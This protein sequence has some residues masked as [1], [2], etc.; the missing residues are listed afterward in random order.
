MVL[1]RR[2]WLA[3]L[4]LS[5]PLAV[6]ALTKQRKKVAM[7]PTFFILYPR[8]ASELA[9]GWQRC[10]A[11]GSTDWL[12]PLRLSVPLAVGA[13][14]KQRKRIATQAFFVLISHLASELAVGGKVSW[15]TARRI[16]SLRCAFPYHSPW[17]PLQNNARRLLRN[18]PFLFYT[19]ALQV[20]LRRGIKQKNGCEAS[21][22]FCGGS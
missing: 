1:L 17:G 13:L 6:G 16:G 21:Q 19:H 10:S 12:A 11:D 8:R 20:N 2:D 14:T 9:V 7:Q 22:P 4:R 3:P 15:L 5:V 18:L